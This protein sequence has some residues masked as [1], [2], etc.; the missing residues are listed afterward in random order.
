METKKQAFNLIQAI[1]HLNETAWGNHAGSYEDAKEAAY[2]VEEALEGIY[3][4]EPNELGV[5]A[6][7]GANPK[8]FARR[9]ISQA[10]IGGNHSPMPDVDRFDKALDA[11]Y[12][13]IGSMHK[14]GLSP[15]QI[16]E[17]LQV[18]HTANTQKSGAKDAQGK[19]GKPIDFV[20]PEVK[21]QTILDKRG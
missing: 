4:P 12:F 1:C 3:N 7:Y 11:I 8:E 19:V 14:L 6:A 5:I 17:G 15:Y 9:I 2:Q 13:A 18:V 20:N 10:V 16:V 21:L